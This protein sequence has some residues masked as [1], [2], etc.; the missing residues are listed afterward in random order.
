MRQLA[1]RWLN[2]IHLRC[3]ARRLWVMTPSPP[4]KAH[5]AKPLKAP[6]FLHRR[7]DQPLSTA[8][9]MILEK[10]DG[11]LQAAILA[12]RSEGHGREQAKKLRAMA[13][14]EGPEKRLVI[15]AHVR[16]VFLT[17]LEDLRRPVTND[18]FHGCQAL[19]GGTFFA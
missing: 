14:V 2:L 5:L 8:A 10:D 18:R 15:V 13:F 1:M 16:Q 3:S 19:L 17:V 6:R 4:K 11:L 12:T 7:D 9:L